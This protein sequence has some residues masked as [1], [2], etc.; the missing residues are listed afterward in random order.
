MLVVGG[1]IDEA[2][3]GR[4]LAEA[5]EALLGL[6]AVDWLKRRMKELLRAGRPSPGVA[7]VNAGM[8]GVLA[9]AGTLLLKPPGAG[10]SLSAGS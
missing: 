10:K 4:V 5:V 3:D 7:P 2:S 9:L 8:L 6:R 1:G